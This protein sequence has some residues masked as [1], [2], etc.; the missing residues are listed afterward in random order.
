MVAILLTLIVLFFLVRGLLG[1]KFFQ[2]FILL[3]T[4][5]GQTPELIVISTTVKN[6]NSKKHISE[7]DFKTYQLHCWKLLVILPK[8]SENNI[9]TLYIGRPKEDGI[10]SFNQ[11]CPLCL[12]HLDSLTRECF[13]VNCGHSFHHECVVNLFMKDS[14]KCP[15]CKQD[16]EKRVRRIG[17]KTKCNVEAKFYGSTIS[18]TL[19]SE[20]DIV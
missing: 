14:K 2:R 4:K 12:D 19:N 17:K 13:T 8:L 20:A 6:G 5:H 16:F 11:L 7:S 10:Q 9:I 1:I 3:S 15:L 18:T